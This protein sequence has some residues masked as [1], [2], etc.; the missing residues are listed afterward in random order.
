MTIYEEI[1]CDANTLYK[2]YKKTMEGSDWK[3][4][5][6][7]F[8]LNFLR[9]IFSIQNDLMNRTL[10][11]GHTNEFMQ[12]ER[13]KIRPITS[14][15][16][17]DRVIRHALMDDILMPEIEK[18]IIKE[19]C[20]SIKN[21]GLEV[22]REIF[23]EHLKS[24][25]REYGTNEGWILFGDFSKFYDNIIH[26]IAKR[27]L[28]KLVD[29]DPF[30]T[31]LLDIIFKGFEIDVSYMSEE[32]YETCLE[33]CFNKIT[34]REIP[35]EK[36]TGEKWMAKSCN[37]GDQLSQGVGIYYPHRIDTYA[38]YVKSQKRY[39]RYQDDW[40][41]INQ[42][43]EELLDI[44]DGIRGIAKEY[45][46]HIN[47]KKT[48]IVKISSTYK[49][50]QIKYSMRSDGKLIRRINPKRVT[51]M[52]RRLKKLAIKLENGEVP[53]ENIEGMFKGWMGSFYKLLS[54]K[55][56][57]NL[58]TLYEDLFNKSIT[59]K[60]MPNGKNKMIIVDKT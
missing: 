49:F 30:I 33:D 8:S 7:R 21:R 55:Q 47:E 28:A 43:K 22:Q 20:A 38:K 23:E 29:N 58:L 41:D 26:E 52:R 5:A 35:K 24:Y 51:T 37:I 44:L 16:V 6:Q 3:E 14:L 10:K 25:Y 9:H 46:I 19:N 48:K 59:I 54:R 18:H 42:S 40:Y 34:Y 45:G 11:N 39:G 36:L 13:G 50:L 57:E 60:K 27:E 15:C 32:E 17:R 4:T 1:M 31:W 2:A 12:N 53:Y 56:R